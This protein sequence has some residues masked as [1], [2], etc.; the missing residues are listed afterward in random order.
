MTAKR[1]WFVKK[2]RTSQPADSAKEIDISWN[3]SSSED[4]I[5]LLHC[6]KKF[7]VKDNNRDKWFD[8]N[9]ITPACDLADL[10][11]STSAV[12][13]FAESPILGSPCQNDISP[14]LTQTEDLFTNVSPVIG[15][16]NTLRRPKDNAT[17]SVC[18]KLTDNT[19]IVE[20][21]SPN[22]FSTQSSSYAIDANCQSPERKTQLH[23][24]P[25]SSQN[26]EDCLIGTYRSEDSSKAHVS[27]TA[28]S[29]VSKTSSASYDEQPSKRKRKYKKGGLAYQLQK[30][31]VKQRTNSAIWQHEIYLN[32]SKG[33]DDSLQ[34]SGA[35]RL[36]VQR[37]W[38]E[39]GNT[40]VFCDYAASDKRQGNE[41]TFET[42]RNNS[43]LL[44]VG[45]NNSINSNF[46]KNVAVSLH[47][48]YNTKQILYESRLL[49]CH[50][51][52]SRYVISTS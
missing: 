14:A 43:C 22:L 39:Y 15:G 47:M 33:D 34:Y 20:E 7:K 29:L 51:N 4:E 46:E 10:K 17:S 48:P 28:T 27:S 37:T 8:C 32:K 1:R 19:E 2:F 40:F 6:T 18:R 30:A 31:L 25:S 26:A 35:I 36:I 13:N 5:Q 3:S 52:I 23:I 50:Y 38:S 49:D 45:F 12:H 41:S 16:S 42:K 44:I 11:P 24:S 21:N 9:K